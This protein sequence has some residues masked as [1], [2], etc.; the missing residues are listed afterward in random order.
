MSGDP[1]V[2]GLPQK[3]VRFCVG[4]VVHPRP[5]QVLTELFRHLRLE[6]RVEAATT[7]GEAPYLVVRVA[8]LEGALIIPLEKTSSFFEEEAEMTAAAAGA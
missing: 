3:T 5:L 7:D 8:G 1:A 4:D 6:G 2:D